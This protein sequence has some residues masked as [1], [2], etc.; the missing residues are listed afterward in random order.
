M[1]DTPPDLP[2][3]F[4]ARKGR[5]AQLALWAWAS[6]W[7]LADAARAYGERLDAVQRAGRR[8][9][10]QGIERPPAGL[11]LDFVR[12]APLV[13]FRCAWTELT[14]GRALASR[15]D[16]EPRTGA[17]I[18]DWDGVL[19]WRPRPF[20]W[21]F[22]PGRTP[23]GTAQE[24]QEPKPDAP[25]PRTWSRLP[26]PD[27][28]EYVPASRYIAR[29]M[30]ARILADRD[31]AAPPAAARL[32]P[33]SDAQ[34]REAAHATRARLDAGLA[35]A[36]AHACP[37]SLENIRESDTRARARGYKGEENWAGSARHWAGSARHWAGSARA[38]NTTRAS[39]PATRA[40]GPATRA[41]SPALSDYHRE[42]AERIL[43]FG[44]NDPDRTLAKL[45]Q[46]PFALYVGAAIDAL[47]LHVQS[48]DVRGSVYRWA[49]K[50]L[51]QRCRTLA[52]Q[53]DRRRGESDAQANGQP[54]F[55]AFVQWIMAHGVSEPSA[56]LEAEATAPD[57]RAVFQPWY[58]AST[59]HST[60]GRLLQELRGWRA[61]RRDTGRLPTPPDPRSDPAQ[62][63]VPGLSHQARRDI[64]H[65]Y[66][67]VRTRNLM[68]DAAALRIWD[69]D[70]A[71]A[72]EARIDPGLRAEVEEAERK[73]RE[74]ARDRRQADD[75]RREAQ[76][77][78]DRAMQSEQADIHDQAVKFWHW[79]GSYR[80]DAPPGATDER[81]DQLLWDTCPWPEAPPGKTEQE[82][83]RAYR[84]ETFPSYRDRIR[85]KPLEAGTYAYHA[86]R[87]GV[88][89]DNL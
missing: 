17:R 61:I 69:A 55:G 30:R 52:A 50:S 12:D 84:Q 43:G 5:A 39:G 36:R 1:S 9:K 67:L 25:D 76:R 80:K 66:A 57:L 31:A 59:T 20:L 77:H 62:A 65:G 44:A 14:S 86:Q 40:S 74:F 21:Q 68:R 51:P 15:T 48:G 23:R 2:T 54:T 87:Q 4:P 64:L 75:R 85:A 71:A 27:D 83:R 82:A 13:V 11:D 58:E 41:T 19:Q 88:P 16:A 56:Y 47:C 72:L 6:G 7:T 35:P 3:Q 46:G 18:R 49:K 26:E 63:P 22:P 79:I 37:D 29:R 45:L 78:I 32:Q 42:R 33:I 89:Y 38:E 70:R 34:Y 81:L 53:H 8:L 24:P 60:P 73:A 10:A 28:P